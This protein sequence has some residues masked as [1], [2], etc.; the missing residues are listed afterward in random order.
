M[1]RLLLVCLILGGLLRPAAV[2][3]WDDTGHQIVARIAWEQMTTTARQNVI[4]LLQEAP[5]DACL[6]EMFS[7]DA[8]PLAERQRE[9]FM[10]AATWADKVRRNESAPRPCDRFDMP[11]WHFINYFWEGTSDT[12]RPPPEHATRR[13]PTPNAVTQL[14]SLSA[15]VANQ[16]RPR[17][18]RAT[19]LAWILHLA[20]DIHQP[21]HTTA[22]IT[23]QP[24][25]AQGDRGGNNFRLWTPAGWTRPMSLH[26]YWDNII[27]LSVGQREAEELTDYVE[28]VAIPLMER[29]PRAALSRCLQPGAFEAWAREGFLIT[30]MAL[31]PPDLQ[32]GQRPSEAYQRRAHAISEQSIALAG[33]RLA[34]LLNQRFGS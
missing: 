2:L 28:R 4:S 9:F 30:R 25:D 5:A 18:E 14:Q 23:P 27:D 13:P 20:G 7:T 33:Y 15:S 16:S 21:L 31:Y 22:R 12:D 17:A 1:K 6:R 32:R 11:Q 19:D 8:R 24:E 3:A 34:E 10:R 29:H 26:S